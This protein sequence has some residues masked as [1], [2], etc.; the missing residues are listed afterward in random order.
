[1]V[2]FHT[3]LSAFHSAGNHG[4]LNGLAIA[5]TQ[6]FH[7]ALDAVRAKETHE[8]VFQRKVEARRAGVALTARAATQLVVDAAAFVAFCAENVQAAQIHNAFA[9]HDVRA[10]ASHIGGNGDTAFLACQ[11]HDF[12]FFFMLLGIEHAVRD[13]ELAQSMR[14]HFGRFNGNCAHK[15]WL[16]FFVQ[17]GNGFNYGVKLFLPR[18]VDKVRIIL[19]NHGPVGRNG[20]NLE[21]VDLMEFHSFGIRSTRHA[22]KLVVQ[23]EVVLEGDGGKGLVFSGNGDVFLGFQSLMQAIRIAAASHKAASEFV[24]NNNLIFLNNIVH[25]ALENLMRLERLH[26]MVLGRDVGWVKKVVQL[27]QLFA[28][29]HAFIGEHGGAGLFVNR[30][31]LRGELTDNVVHSAVHAHRFIRCAGNDERRSGFVDED[32]VHFVH[33]GK[34]VPALHQLVGVELHVVA[35]IVK[36]EFIIGAI[37]DILGVFGFALFVIK[38]MHNNARAQA[39]EFIQLAHPGRVALGEVVVD[40][41]HMHAL[42]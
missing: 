29:G 25:I 5:Q 18:P 8:V 38:A 13:T 36:A 37:G 10:A 16:L 3:F 34:I 27:E 28:P 15:H 2:G 6:L 39:E 17:F 19:A 31:V 21:A 30:V 32:G 20:D 26:H 9:Q 40:R 33:N 12:G 7:Q 24:N 4:V 23:A 35:Q 41:D 14:K 42:A 11:R 1:M 22:R